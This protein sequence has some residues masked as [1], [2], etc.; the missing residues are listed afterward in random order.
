MWKA[1]NLMP[2]LAAI[3]DNE[4]LEI[5][6]TDHLQNKKNFTFSNFSIGIKKCSSA[7]SPQDFKDCSRARKASCLYCD[8]Q[9]TDTQ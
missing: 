4:P 2:N 1:R 8:K 9:R 6:K 3:V 7:T 5:V